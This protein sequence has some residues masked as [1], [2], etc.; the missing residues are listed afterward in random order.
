MNNFVSYA[1]F[2]IITAFNTVSAFQSQYGQDQFI[3][4]S[5]FSQLT[6][7]V[8]VDIGAHDGI[9][10]SNSFYFESEKKWSGICIE[11][12]PEV[13]EK[14]KINRNCRCIQGCVADFTGRS[15]FL[16][17]HGYSEMLSGLISKYDERHLERIFKEIE[18]YGGSCEIIEVQC[19]TI[20][21]LLEESGISNINY[22]SIDT[23]GGEFD[24]I[25][26]I[27]YSKFH[28]D[29][30]SVEDNYGDLRFNRFLEEKGFHL[31]SIKGR[32]LIFVNQTLSVG[33]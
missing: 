1:L 29:V 33:S 17:V 32:D 4:H 6:D 25:S 24:I 15:Q 31:I 16:R 18:C 28:I 19:Y 27:D 12:M 7:G 23:E 20:N 21:D 11:P 9:T 5:F 14:L 3:Y 8:F 10:L 22:L 30:I 13:F 26:S 2:A